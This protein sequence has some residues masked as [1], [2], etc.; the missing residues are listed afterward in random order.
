MMP[1]DDSVYAQRIDD[2]RAFEREYRARLRIFLENGLA[3][4]DK[5]GGKTLLA[6]AVQRIA[7]APDADLAEVLA[8][9][10]EHRRAHL[11]SVLLR[12]PVTEVTT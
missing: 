9:L 6:A 11:L 10:T 2:L 3:E 12:T 5:P 1:Q 7:Q 4:L 8:D